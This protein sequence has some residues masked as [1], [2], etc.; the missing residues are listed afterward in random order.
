LA[1]IAAFVVILPEWLIGL[2]LS[3]SPDVFNLTL[4]VPVITTPLE[5]YDSDCGTRRA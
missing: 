2:I 5:A 1:S 3:V 4:K